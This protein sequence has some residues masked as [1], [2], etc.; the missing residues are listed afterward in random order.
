MKNVQPIKKIPAKE[1]LRLLEEAWSYYL[2]EPMP[3]SVIDASQLVLF[4]YHNAA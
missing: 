3:K 2:P 1:A 4:Q